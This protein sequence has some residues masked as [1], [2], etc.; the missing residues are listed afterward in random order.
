MQTQRAIKVLHDILIG[1]RKREEFTLKRT[2]PLALY[3]S[4]H[5]YEQ[6]RRF[7]LGC[8]LD[9]RA[10]EAI[11]LTSAEALARQ[12]IGQW[13][14]DLADNSLTWSDAVYDIF[15]LTRGARITRDETVALFCEDSRAAMERLRDY[16]IK[17]SRGF[18]LD[19]EIRPSG[20]VRR[21]MRLIAAP[22]S[23]NGRVVR[24]HGLKRIIPSKR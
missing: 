16:A 20:R 7:D 9:S 11:G 13:H 15:E 18:T 22:L 1:F 8:I 17:H 5:L 12:G 14:C 23:D 3:H 4:W 24:L 19:A 10:T 21:W 2:E 6:E